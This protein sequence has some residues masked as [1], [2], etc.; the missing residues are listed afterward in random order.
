MAWQ[1][2]VT[3]NEGNTYLSS[4]FTDS[5]TIGD[6]VIYKNFPIPASRVWLAKLRPNGEIAWLK[7]EERTLSEVLTFT[8]IKLDRNGDIILLCNKANA[9]EPDSVQLPWIGINNFMT[10]IKFSKD[11]NI[12]NKKVLSTPLNIN[13]P[14]FNLAD[15]NIDFDNNLIFTA[16]ASGKFLFENSLNGITE[17]EPIGVPFAGGRYIFGK[18]DTNFRLI[19]VNQIH[20]TSV[21]EP[22][23]NSFAFDAD[24]NIVLVGVSP[25]D[26]LILNEIGTDIIYNSFSLNSN[27]GSGWVMKLKSDGSLYWAKMMNGSG[28]IE[29]SGV[30][31]DNKDNIYISGVGSVLNA[32]FESDTGNVYGR[33]WGT[34]I[35]KFTPNGNPLIISSTG[36]SPNFIGGG[37]GNLIDTDS[38]GNIYVAGSF[39]GTVDF[40]PGPGNEIF[41]STN[42]SISPGLRDN[43]IAKY[44]NNLS[45][46]WL[47]R[48]TGTLNDPY[49]NWSYSL[50]KGTNTIAFCGNYTGI[51]R[52]NGLPL[53]AYPSRQADLGLQGAP[54]AFYAKIKNNCLSRTQTHDTICFGNTKSFD[55]E[56]LSKPGKYIRL[57]SYN[58][59]T[60]CEVWEELYLHVRPEILANAGNDVSVCSG[61][62]QS[63]GTDSLPGLSYQWQQV[64]GSFTSTQARP[65][66]GY[67]NFSDSIQRYRFALQVTDSKGCQKLDTVQLAISPV[68]RASL[69]KT[70]C[71]GETFEGYSTSGTFKDTLVSSLGCDSIRTLTLNYNIPNNSIQLSAQFGALAAPGQDG[72][73]WLDCNAGFAPIPGETDSSFAP[74]VSGSYAVQVT[75]GNCADTSGCLFLVNTEPTVVAKSGLNIFPNPAQGFTTIDCPSCKEG[76]TIEI[77]CTDGSRIKILNISPNKRLTVE[78]LPAGVF[79]VRVKG[80]HF[81]PEKLVIW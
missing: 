65:K 71:P 24:N 61:K 45:F 36:F 14:L 32:Y 1:S 26:T 63:L 64:G 55:G 13:G 49:T 56:T 66:P 37:P 38:A 70:I 57:K 34:L 47:A 41:T 62:V 28:N 79:T 27:F 58:A 4:N 31:I 60:Q 19:W 48:T 3:D 40:D 33:Q 20:N 10:I 39:T 59:S 2:C 44:S 18:L 52:F 17:I 68:L 23:I 53:P 8:K 51:L 15:F 25:S 78:G 76:Q 67:T 73:Q 22:I 75:K 72:Y 7:V 5:V 12:K 46:L 29:F 43:F 80:H 30:S 9:F 21:R 11:G 54:D 42:S 50:D 74:T 6:S 16:I 81:I 69:V 35:N 77:F